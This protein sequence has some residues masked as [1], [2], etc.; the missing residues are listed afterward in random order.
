MCPL[1]ARVS[2]RRLTAR[3]PDCTLSVHVPHR[4]LTLARPLIARSQC[5]HPITRTH[6]A[7]FDCT[8]PVHASVARSRRLRVRHSRLPLVCDTHVSPPFAIARSQC[9][10]RVGIKQYTSTGPSRHQYTQ[11]AP[12]TAHTRRLTPGQ[13]PPCSASDRAP[14]A[15]EVLR[16]LDLGEF[17]RPLRSCPSLAIALS[18]S[19]KHTQHTH[20]HTCSGGVGLAAVQLAKAAGCIVIGTASRCQSLS[21]P[22]SS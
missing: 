13:H 7:S 10:P 8:I 18:Y 20:T 5:T 1:M 16:R 3:N 2:D 6:H 14:H 17:P 12:L 15:S 4:T 22:F 11:Y 19:Q 9:K 21:G